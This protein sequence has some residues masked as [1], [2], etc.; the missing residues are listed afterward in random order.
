MRDFDAIPNAIWNLNVILKILIEIIIIIVTISPPKTVRKFYFHIGD[1]ESG[2][3]K[4][5]QVAISPETINVCLL[6]ACSKRLPSADSCHQYR[7]GITLA[8]F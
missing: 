7:C 1:H 5:S 6:F 3:C 2:F 4:I 8:N